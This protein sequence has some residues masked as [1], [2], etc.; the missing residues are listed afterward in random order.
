MEDS[1]AKREKALI[2]ARL[3]RVRAG[4]LGNWKVI[5]GEGVTGLYELKI[6]DGPGYRIY[7]GKEDNTVV[8]LLCG[9]DKGSQKRDTKK[10]AAYWNDYKAS[11]G[12]KK[13][14]GIK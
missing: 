3:I 5:K 1:L 4:N 7:F 2:H 12:V 11:K 8:I 9:G 14:R 10:A 6:D 13:K